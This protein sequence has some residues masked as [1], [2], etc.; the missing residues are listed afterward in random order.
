[1]PVFA[2]SDWD[3]SLISF[4]MVEWGTMVHKSKLERLCPSEGCQSTVWDD[5]HIRDKDGSLPCFSFY[6]STLVTKPEIQ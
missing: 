2:L 6:N 1:M 3:I 4:S 5:E